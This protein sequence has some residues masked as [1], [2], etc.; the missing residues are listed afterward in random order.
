MKVRFSTRMTQNAD[1]AVLHV[2]SVQTNTSC[3]FAVFSFIGLFGKAKQEKKEQKLVAV[4]LISTRVHLISTKYIDSTRVRYDSNYKV[5]V[6]PFSTNL[7]GML[8]KHKLGPRQTCGFYSAL[9]QHPKR[10]RGLHH[11]TGYSPLCFQSN[12]TIPGSGLFT[13]TR[14]DTPKEILRAAAQ[15][16]TQTEWQRRAP[17]CGKA[18]TGR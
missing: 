7:Q 5:G 3:S 11:S 1:S 16:L 8:F 18:R 14:R 4:V 17:H 6:R 15:R 12:S 9:Y 13:H 2:L 10:H